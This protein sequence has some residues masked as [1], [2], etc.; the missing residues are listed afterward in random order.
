MKL[1]ITGYEQE[2]PTLGYYTLDEDFHARI[3]VQKELSFPSFI[4]NN[5][6]MLFTFQKEQET[7]LLSL[8]VEGDEVFE[9][10]HMAIPGGK[11]THLVYSDKQQALFGCSYADG[12]FFSAKCIEGK[13]IE[14][15]TYQKQIQ[16]NIK[17]YCHCVLLNRQEDRLAI[18]NI[19]TDQVFFYSIN[20][21]VL[22]EENKLKLPVGVGP[23]HGIYNQDCSL[24]YLVTEY[25]NEVYVVRM[26][27]FTIIQRIS[28]IP[29]YYETNYGATLVF[30]KDYL[31]LYASNRGEDS[32][33][34]YTVTSNGLLKYD[35]SFSCGGKHPRHMILSKDG[36]YIISC[37]KN[38]N[39]V[40]IIDLQTEEV[41]A[42][43]PFLSP[44][45]VVEL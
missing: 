1:V 16:Q 17:S 8:V 33:A 9:K 29:N 39:Q 20:K 36:K 35:H 18:I 15:L 23:R 27:D 3:T 22:I 42:S 7:S 28:T 32:I 19:A 25:S 31:H 30:S 26:S 11:P 2:Q 13:F 12:T 40:A 10:D 4:I 21:G 45:G 44:S 38:N 5:N 43:I 14:L 41:I 24:L 37:N 34:K 6:S